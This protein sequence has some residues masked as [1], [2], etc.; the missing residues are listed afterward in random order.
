MRQDDDRA[1][2]GPAA[3]G[4]CPDPEGQQ[5]RP[6]RDR[7][8]PEDGEPASAL[9][10]ARDLD[11]VPGCDER[12][13]PGPADRPADRRAD[14]GSSRR[15]ARP[16]AQAG[17]R[18]PRA[19]RHPAWASRRVSA[20]A[21]GRDASAGDDRDGPRLRPGDRHRRRADDRPRRHGPGPDPGA[22]RA[23]PAGARPVAHPDH[24]RPVGDRRDLRP[25]PDHVRRTRRRGGPRLA[26]LHRARDTPT[27]R[28][29]SVRSRTSTPTGAA[30]RRSPARRRTCATRPRAAGS[31]RAAPR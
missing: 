17:S 7:P 25:G 23:P 26:D 29:S 11:R 24:P 10:L 19:R 14:R 9:P 4:E 13:E 2:P 15:V 8:G 5:H 28:S 27:P 16:V 20:R 12:P 31:T 1:V 6:V 3:A 30:W 22:P 18:A 21:V